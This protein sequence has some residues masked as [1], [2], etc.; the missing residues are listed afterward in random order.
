MVFLKV[1]SQLLE[2]LS[3]SC[4]QSKSF[5]IMIICSNYSCIINYVLYNAYIYTYKFLLRHYTKYS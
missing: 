1:P 2:F 5:T 4:I 3:E